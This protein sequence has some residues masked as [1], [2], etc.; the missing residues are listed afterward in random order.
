LRLR[1]VLFLVPAFLSNLCFSQVLVTAATAE[2]LPDI[3]DLLRSLHANQKNVEQLIK[4]YICT[5]DE[6]VEELDGDG[7]IKKTTASQYDA[8]YVGRTQIRRTIVREGSQVR[9]IP[10]VRPQRLGTHIRTATHR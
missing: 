6:Q 5:N 4:Y 7:S 3:P 10:R 9:R 1:S 2:P 8:F